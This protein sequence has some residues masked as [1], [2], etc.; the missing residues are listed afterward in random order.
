LICSGPDG[1]RFDCKQCNDEW[2]E[3]NDE[4]RDLRNCGN[5]KRLLHDILIGAEWDRVPR[6]YHDHEVIK[7]DDLKFF[8]CPLTTITGVTWELLRQVNLCCNSAGEIIHLPEPDLSILDQ[9]PRF[10]KAVELVRNE[11]NSEWFRDMQA[12]W[13]KQG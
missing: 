12:K 13:A 8:A 11:R 7:I 9:S 2:T 6:G 4:Q 3:N 10:L 5:R 1:H